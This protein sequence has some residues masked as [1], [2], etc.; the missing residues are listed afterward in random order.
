MIG[1]I[2][3]TTV[4]RRQEFLDGDIISALEKAFEEADKIVVAD[5]LENN[6]MNGCTAVVGVVVDGVLHIANIGD[7]EGILVSV[8]YVLFFFFFSK[9]LTHF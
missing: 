5:S 6:Y 2:L 1:D 4:F 8:E 9:H 3:H 7:S